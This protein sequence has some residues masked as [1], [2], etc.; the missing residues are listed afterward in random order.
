MASKRTPPEMP[1]PGPKRPAPSE[2]QRVLCERVRVL[3]ER[4]A[5]ETHRLRLELAQAIREARATGLSWRG[6]EELT[7]MRHQTMQNILSH[8]HK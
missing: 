1:L 6:M 2:L 4:E 3:R 5:V 8:N 7:G